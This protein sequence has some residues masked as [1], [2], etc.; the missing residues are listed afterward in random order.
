[1]NARLSLALTGFI[2]VFLVAINV[3]QI[4]HDHLIGAIIVGFLISLT[5]TFNVKRIAFG[6]HLDRL[7]Y[8]SGA[9]AGTL[10]GILLAKAIY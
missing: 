8:S 2:Q 5:W 4:S 6:D 3:W 7:I 10:C 1:V 9:A